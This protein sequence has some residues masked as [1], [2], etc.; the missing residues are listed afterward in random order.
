MKSPQI[1]QKLKQLFNVSTNDEIIPAIET[2]LSARS[3]L[4][5][6]VT[7]IIANGQVVS[8]PFGLSSP[9]KIAEIETLQ[10]VFRSLANS[11][12]RQKVE[13]IR[14]ELARQMKN[15]EQITD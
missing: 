9:P 1:T 4:P 5:L 2:V 8:T 15:D 11:L 14:A 6:G 10:N 7:I 3:A 12:D 13:L